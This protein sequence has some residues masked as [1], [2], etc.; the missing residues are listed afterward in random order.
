MRL[1]EGNVAEM[2][3]SDACGSGVDASASVSTASIEGVASFFTNGGSYMP[4]I[5]CIRNAS[6]GPD[7][8]WIIVLLVLTGG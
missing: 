7:W 2:L 5:E 6:G 1:L 8:P 3:A 4:R